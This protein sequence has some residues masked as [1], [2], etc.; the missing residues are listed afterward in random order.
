[1]K[2]TEYTNPLF[3]EMFDEI[4][5]E[6]RRQSSLSFSIAARIAELLK[7]KG[8]SQADLA[9]AAGK[10]DAEISRW[11]SGTHNFTLKTISLIET[12]MGEELIKVKRKPKLVDGY[13]YVPRSAKTY[14]NDSGTMHSSTK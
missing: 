13:G 10:K 7:K 12:V 4:P 5:E 11:M 9:K 2:S 1:M 3:A 8:W 6:S 14:L